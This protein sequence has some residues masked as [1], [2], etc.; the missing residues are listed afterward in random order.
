MF[1]SVMSRLKP[2]LA[3]LRGYRLPRLPLSFAIVPLALVLA[4]VFGWSIAW[5]AVAGKN[6]AALDA[7]LERQARMNRLYSCDDRDVGGFPFKLEVRC[8]G[9]TAAITDQRGTAIEFSLGQAVFT[10]RIFRANHITMTAQGPF[11]RKGDTQH[12]QWE[13]RWG[14][15]QASFE[16]QP[17]QASYMLDTRPE[18]MAVVVDGLVV[19]RLE[20]AGADI[21]ADKA[22]LHVRPLERDAQALVAALTLD[23]AFFG[24]SQ[25][26]IDVVFGA[27]MRNLPGL[28]PRALSSWLRDFETK[29]GDITITQARFTNALIDLHLRGTG[30]LDSDGRPKGT[31]TF[32]GRGIAQLPRIMPADLLPDAEGQAVIGARLAVEA[33]RLAIVVADGRLF[34]AGQPVL[35]VAS[36]Y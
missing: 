12:S 31:F 15:A 26:G 29:S 3:A 8:S 34:V 21:V 9:L 18:K 24:A 1:A 10:A 20:K 17:E 33:N 5:W 27:H 35:D 22:E 13:A 23:R 30:G 36:L 28:H 6:M 14:R 25:T 19:H 4:A 2:R 16:W 7:W 32:N 11:V